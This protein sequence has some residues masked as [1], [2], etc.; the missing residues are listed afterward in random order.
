MKEL[1]TSLDWHDIEQELRKLGKS[2]PEFKFNIIKFCGGIQNE[3]RKLSDI[4]I[5]LR[6]RPSDSLLVKHKD[7]ATKINEALKIFSQT[8][9]SHLFSRV[10]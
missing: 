9:L 10:D 5:D 8:H 1:E 7:Q 4:E 3:I 2:A 6:R